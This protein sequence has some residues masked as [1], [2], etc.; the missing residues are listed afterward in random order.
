MFLYAQVNKKGRSLA[1][2][3]LEKKLKR[4]INNHCKKILTVNSSTSTVRKTS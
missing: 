2:I 1:R 3:Y 4:T